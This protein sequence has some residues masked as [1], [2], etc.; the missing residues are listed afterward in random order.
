MYS[1]VK[2]MRR[3]VSRRLR[4]GEYL[5]LHGPFGSGK[6]TLLTEL[7]SRLHKAGARCACAPATQC[8]DDIARALELLNSQA[9]PQKDGQQPHPSCAERGTHRTGRVLLLDHL[10]DFNNAMVRRLRRVHLGGVGVLIAVDVETEQEQQMRLWRLGGAVAVRMPPIG[11]EQ[12]RNLLHEGRSRGRLPPL[13][14][15]FESSLIRAAR[16]RPGWILQCIELEQRGNYW[17]GEQLFASQLSADTETA[18]RGALHLLRHESLPEMSTTPPL[19][20]GASY[21]PDGST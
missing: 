15:E 8:L 18:L 14:P 6:T 4:R 17:Q 19:V 7:Q 9:E 16:G 11:A 5:I 13:R 3:D 12:L 2:V 21:H 20:A 1:S 10:T